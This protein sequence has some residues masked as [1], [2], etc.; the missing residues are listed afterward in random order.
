MTDERDYDDEDRIIPILKP[1]PPLTLTEFVHK[2]KNLLDEMH[3]DHEAEPDETH[4]W[5]YWSEQ[6]TN[7]YL[8]D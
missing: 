4:T 3:N 5:D 8:N 2:A 7:A 6:L 1:A